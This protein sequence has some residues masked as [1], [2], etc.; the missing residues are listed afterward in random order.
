MTKQTPEQAAALAQYSLSAIRVTPL[1]KGLINKTFCVEGKTDRCVLQQVN[2]I[3]PPEVNLDI[4]AVTRH[5]E[6]HGLPTCRLIPTAEGKLWA[7]VGGQTWR[8]LTWVD[9]VSHDSL[10]T[11]VQASSAGRL[12]ALFHEAVADLEHVF[13]SPRL[14]IHDTE[15]HLAFLRQ[16]LQAKTDHPQFAAIEPL[17]LRILEAAEQLPDYPETADRIVHGDPK[18][19]NI[20]FDAKTDE[21]FS[22][23]DLDTLAKMPL[24]LELGDALRSWCNPA[25]EDDQISEFSAALFAE[26][27]NGYAEGAHD[28]ITPEEVRSIVPATQ[29]ILVELASRFCADALNESYFGWRPDLF[30]NRSQHNQVRA[31][32][33]LTVAASLSAQRGQLEQ[34]VARAFEQ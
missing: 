26:A 25:G 4:D 20:M 15:Q 30:A 19:N 13:T 17:A 3:F 34:I 24:P 2:P 12:L 10:A 32:S 16:T 33:Q 23:V 29:R 21:A 18:I 6:A 8:L 28:W 22:L 14:G 31:A 5:I 7:T 27:V 1:G 9:G 11:A